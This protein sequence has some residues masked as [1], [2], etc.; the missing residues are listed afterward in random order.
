MDQSVLSTRVNSITQTDHPGCGSPKPFLLVPGAARGLTTSLF[1]STSAEEK[2][3]RIKGEET[4]P[5]QFFSLLVVLV[6]TRWEK[7]C[8]WLKWD[9]GIVSELQ[10]STLSLPLITRYTQASL[11]LQCQLRTQ[12]NREWHS[13][14]RPFMYLLNLNWSLKMPRKQTSWTKVTRLIK[15]VTPYAS[16]FN[17]NIIPTIS[18]FHDQIYASW[19]SYRKT[20]NL[21]LMRHLLCSRVPDPLDS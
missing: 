10:F 2:P 4:Q 16:H 7:N 20:G 12:V 11:T 8:Y 9:T 19:F 21:T 13:N 17:L 6:T 1:I 3:G 14:S 15:A 18:T 5:S